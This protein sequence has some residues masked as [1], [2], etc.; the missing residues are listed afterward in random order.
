MEISEEWIA[1][2]TRFETDLIKTYLD[3]DKKQIDPSVPEI[4]RLLETGTCIHCGSKNAYTVNRIR[5]SAT[6]IPGKEGRDI[7][8]RTVAGPSPS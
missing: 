8:A 7:C 6:V 2:L 1:S 5:S 4:G 3:T